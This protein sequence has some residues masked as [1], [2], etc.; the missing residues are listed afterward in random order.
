MITDQNSLLRLHRPGGRIAY[1]IGGSGPLVVTSPGMGELRSNFRELSSALMAAGFR[2]ANADLRGHGD[3]DAAF[4]GYGDE[5]TA[6]DLIALIE[7]LGAPAV[8]VGNSMS[9]GS[10]V[11]VAS[12]RPDLV[13][14][15]VLSGPFVRN[16]PANPV[17][18]AVFR[19]LMTRPWAVAV[20][21]AYLPSLY[22]GRR[23]RGF[24]AHRAQIRDSMR[25]PGH[26]AAFARTTR[27]S[28]ALSERLLPSVAAPAL[29][30]MGDRDPDFADPVVEA[31]WIATTLD[32]ATLDSDRVDGSPEAV[33]VA[34]SAATEVVMVEDSGHYPHAQRPDVVVP[35]V[36][37]FLARVHGPVADA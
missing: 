1:D 20:W 17:M 36:L 16:P 32:S 2:V 4:A 31:A 9:A 35:E 14:G 8:V 37:A 27:T 34:A 7:H 3:S 12:R 26:A 33:A 13:A 5:E 11:I 25:R 19:V 22:A 6:E 28:H 15:L 24:D 29:V 18:Q 23:P 10:A 21:N 30:V